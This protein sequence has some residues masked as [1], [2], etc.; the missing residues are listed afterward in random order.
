LPEITGLVP[1]GPLNDAPMR[2]AIRRYAAAVLT[3]RET[4]YSAVTSILRKDLPRMRGGR[5][6]LDS[7]ADQL[8]ATVDAV[9]RMENTHLVIQGP[10]GSGK[11]FTSA[12]AIVSLLAENKRVGVMSMSHKAINNL[13]KT[14]EE[15]AAERGV[16]FAGIKK[17][18]KDEDCLCGNVI[19]DSDDNDEV[20]GGDHGLIGGTAWLFSRPEMDQKLD[21]LFVD[22]AGQVSLADIVATGLSAKNFVLVGDQ[23]QLGQPTKGKHPGGSGVSGLDYL[24]GAWATVPDDRGVFLEHTWRMHPTLC[25]FI[26]DAFYDGKLR[27]AECTFG[28]RLELDDYLG[29]TLG[30]F[31]LRFVAVDHKGNTQRS[32]E[33]AARLKDAYHALLGRPW[34]N[35]KGEMRP[36]TTEDVLVVSP[37]NMQVNLLKRT[38]PLGARVGT[39]DKFQGQEAAVVLVSMAA[40]DADSAPRGIDFLFE[41]NRLNV[42]ISRARCLSVMFCS[43][44]LLDVVCADL[45]RMT[46]VSTVCWANESTLSQTWREEAR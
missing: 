15:V 38:L 19:T 28:Q 29:G 25:R 35:Q 37:Y 41:K 39:V 42:A 45:G 24:M 17:A 30:R 13:L 18:S 14:V 12:H 1:S 21:Y 44:A 34:T 22:E 32:E 9:M 46:L 11:T 27:S 7:S 26:S 40:S 43:P 6:I 20:C 4:D 8:S 33:E 2:E 31:G 23:M 36:M 10:P 3:E 16:Q 5:V